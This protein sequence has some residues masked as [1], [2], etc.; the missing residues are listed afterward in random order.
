MGFSTKL[1]TP[2]PEMSGY[3]KNLLKLL[4]QNYCSKDSPLLCK[5]MEYKIEYTFKRCH[6]ERPVKLS[7]NIIGY[8]FQSSGL[9]DSNVAHAT[10]CQII[11]E[12]KLGNGSF[13]SVHD[14]PYRIR[15]LHDTLIVD[16]RPEHKL[17]VV[18]IEK[19]KYDDDPERFENRINQAQNITKFAKADKTG[20]KAYKIPVFDKDTPTTTHTA[21]TIMRKEPGITLEKLLL[22]PTYKHYSLADRLHLAIKLTKELLRIHTLGFAKRGVIHYDIKPENIMVNIVDGEADIHIIDYGISYQKEFGMD[23][24]K[25]ASPQGTIYYMAPELY[26]TA[27]DQA[28]KSRKIDVYSMGLVLDQVFRGPL[29]FF[30]GNHQDNIKQERTSYYQ[31]ALDNINY[32]KNHTPK[33]SINYCIAMMLKTDQSERCET[34][35]VAKRLEDIQNYM[36]KN[37]LNIALDTVLK[38]SEFVANYSSTYE[39][40][41]AIRA[42]LAMEIN[43]IRKTLM[44]LLHSDKEV[45]QIEYAGILATVN[46]MLDDKHE[47][48]FSRSNHIL[49]DLFNNLNPAKEFINDLTRPISTLVGTIIEGIEVALDLETNKSKLFLEQGFFHTTGAKVIYKSRMAWNKNLDDHSLLGTHRI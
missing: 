13:G 32:E 26:S 34:S 37:N 36:F 31:Q 42:A 41:R 49:E 33:E 9:F 25:Q 29:P 16:E 18:K 40:H 47:L 2:S 4:I 48:V 1:V 35:D 20:I 17:R 38:I 11:A 3:D 46:A 14:G 44:K 15:I 43:T 19:N 7:C 39:E 5:D 22:S 8:K 24:F 28:N 12:D 10:H 6:I 27:K 45:T 23:T 30:F 21:Y